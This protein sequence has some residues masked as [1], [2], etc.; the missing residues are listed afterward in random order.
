MPAPHLMNASFSHRFRPV[1]VEFGAGSLA[2]LGDVVAG[3][4]LRRAVVVSTPG[5][6]AAAGAARDALG[7]GVVG[8]FD[9]AAPHVPAALVALALNEAARW[10]ADGTVAVGGG[11]AIGLGKALALR[12]NLPL[13]AVPTTYAGSE[14][15]AVWGIT[16]GDA[17]QTGRDERVAPRAVVYDA[18]LT[19]SLPAEVSAASG[20]NAIAHGVEALYAADA[21]PLAALFAREAVRLLAAALPAVV[22]DPADLAARE[23]ALYGAHLAG[24]ALDM[25]AMGLHHKVCHVLGGTF[26]LPHALTHAI[27]LPHVAAYNAPA[28]EAAMADI[29]AALDAD[30]APAGLYAL[31]RALGI[32]ATL[33]DL[34]LGPADLDRA[35]DLVVAASYPNPREITRGGVRAMLEAAYV[36]APP[37]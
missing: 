1:Y 2:R 22:R 34:G 32:T 6:R 4:G 21:Q 7:A 12:A 23:R 5:R 28:A 15:T 33:R 16:D 8:V 19:V 10:R 3:V 24:R 14:M 36:G 35:A 31:G 30:T 25:T 13:V 37:Q 20:L 29:A 26:G 9:R 11:S 27:L 17:K 18:A